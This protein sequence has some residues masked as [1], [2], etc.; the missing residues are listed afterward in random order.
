MTWK[1]EIA[2]AAGEGQ[3]GEWGLQPHTHCSLQPRWAKITFK[4]LSSRK[5]TFLLLKRNKNMSFQGFIQQLKENFKAFIQIWSTPSFIFTFLSQMNTCWFYLCCWHT[6]VLSLLLSKTCSKCPFFLCTW[7]P[8]WFTSTGD[9]CRHRDEPSF[10][11][12]MDRALR[13]AFILNQSYAFP[14]CR[15]TAM[16]EGLTG[17]HWTLST[18]VRVSALVNPG[19][20]SLTLRAHILQTSLSEAMLILK[21]GSTKMYFI[22]CLHATKTSDVDH[23]DM[24]QVHRGPTTF[25]YIQNPLATRHCCELIPRQLGLRLLTW[26]GWWKY[27]NGTGVVSTG[28]CRCGIHLKNYGDRWCS[29]MFPMLHTASYRHGP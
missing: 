13:Y 10:C 2:V 28:S 22:L 20:G 5:W 14:A 24:R 4:P 18:F 25:L 12:D 15:L 27:E 19:C 26:Y 9:L 8:S 1:A 3:S 23:I 7:C 21:R 6:S 11:S 17:S 29:Q 16:S